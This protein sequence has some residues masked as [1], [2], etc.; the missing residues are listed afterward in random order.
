MIGL[1]AVRVFTK[2]DMFAY[3]GVREPVNDYQGAFSKVT[4]GLSQF[5]R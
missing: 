2:V 5:R 4:K 1:G 3:L